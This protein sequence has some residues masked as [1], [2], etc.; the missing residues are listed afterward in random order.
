MQYE[1]YGPLSKWGDETRAYKRNIAWEGNVIEQLGTILKDI[2]GYNHKLRILAPAA[3][4]GHEELSLAK[5]LSNLLHRKIRMRTSD[6]A[7]MSHAGFYQDAQVT[8]T[9]EQRDAYD[10]PKYLDERQDAI[11]DPKG[12]LWFTMGQEKKLLKALRL[13]YDLLEDDGVII[14]DAGETRK[15]LHAYNV[16]RLNFFMSLTYYAEISTYERLRKCFSTGSQASLLFTIE[17]VP[18]LSGPYGMAILR[19]IPAAQEITA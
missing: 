15:L 14:I 10:L 18:N 5:T 7:T 13:Y 12:I 3:N 6:I 1:K 9:Y 8:F 16:L 4:N 19:K 17:L 2:K 11:Y